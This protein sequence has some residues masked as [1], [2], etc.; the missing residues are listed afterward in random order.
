MT[1]K[2]EPGSF[3][4]VV[5]ITFRFALQIWLI[6]VLTFLKCLSWYQASKTI[7]WINRCFVLHCVV[8][9]T[10]SLLVLGLHVNRKIP[11]CI[12]T[13]RTVNRDLRHWQTRHPHLCSSNN[14]DLIV[15]KSALRRCGLHVYFVVVCHVYTSVCCLQR[16]CVFIVPDRIMTPK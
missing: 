9:W 7:L 6:P 4:S 16:V 12:I 8:M 5:P 3:R 2:F 11:C 10:A 1:W 15:Y 14:D 13:G